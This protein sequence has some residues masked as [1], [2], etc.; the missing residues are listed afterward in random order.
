MPVLCAVDDAVGVTPAYSWVWAS[1]RGCKKAVMVAI[2][3]TDNM[4]SGSGSCPLTGLPF[5]RLYACLSH[6]G[7]HPSWTLYISHSLALSACWRVTMQMLPEDGV[8]PLPTSSTLLVPPAPLLKEENW[9][10]LTI[11]KGFFET[12]A[13]KGAA[14]GAAGG[15]GAAAAAAASAAAAAGGMELDEN[16]LE[17]AGWGDDLD[18]GGEGGGEEGGLEGACGWLVW[19][20]LVFDHVVVSGWV[21]HFGSGL[22]R[23]SGPGREVARTVERKVG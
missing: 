21:C 2:R 13:A 5:L 23:R 8:P 11:S 17:G 12:L 6:T 3:L 10:L 15:V 18:L 4:S 1:R 9:P 16:E 14:A 22:G 20:H 7:I 19:L